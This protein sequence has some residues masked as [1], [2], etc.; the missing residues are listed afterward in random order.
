MLQP[1]CLSVV[2]ALIAAIWLLTAAAPRVVAEPAQSFAAPATA[3]GSSTDGLLEITFAFLVVLA[4]IFALAWLARRAKWLT[5]SGRDRIE[6]V[7]EL[8]LGVKERAVLVR[9]NGFEVLVGVAPGN[10][11]ALHVFPPDVGLASQRVDN[12]VVNEH[13]SAL[14]ASDTNTRPPTFAELLRRSLGR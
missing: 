13:A 10:V 3:S 1:R 9:V 5:S 7:G 11:R 12:A 2:R 4:V 14:T 8:A 6:L